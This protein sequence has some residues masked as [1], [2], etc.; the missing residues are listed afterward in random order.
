VRLWLTGRAGGVRQRCD[1]YER[2][3]I[4]LGEADREQKIALEREAERSASARFAN[5][6]SPAHEDAARPT[7]PLAGRASAPPD[8]AMKYH[9]RHL[10]LN[11]PVYRKVAGSAGPGWRR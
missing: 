4:D 1:A 2:A 7:T 9:G 11:D 8:L 10:G 6:P 5:L 3:A